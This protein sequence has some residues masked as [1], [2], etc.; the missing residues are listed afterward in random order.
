[1]ASKYRFVRD[2]VLRE[3][4]ERAVDHIVDLLALSESSNYGD[5]A[6]SSFRKTVI[7]HTASV[8]EALLL[9]LIRTTCKK[10][11]LTREQWILKDKKIL[12]EIDSMTRIVAGKQRKVIEDID[13]DNMNLGQIN[14]FLFDKRVITEDLFKKIDQVRVLRNEQHL[15]TNKKL[16]D[17]SGENLEFVFSVAKKVKELCERNAR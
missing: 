17:Y 16:K 3:E 10:D 11:D 12:H 7:I 8:I 1:M 6:K 15:G 9:H 13:P 14:I 5:L 4:I 2:T